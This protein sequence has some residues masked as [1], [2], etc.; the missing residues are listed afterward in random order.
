MPNAWQCGYMILII[1]SI[2]K[3]L[4]N[5][6]SRFDVRKSIL[7]IFGMSI[8]SKAQSGLEKRVKKALVTEMLSFSKKD[9][10]CCD[11]NFFMFFKNYL[12]IF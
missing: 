9:E 1:S 5:N 11:A 4:K 10:K 7:D 12:G 6:F 3:I 8:L 2:N